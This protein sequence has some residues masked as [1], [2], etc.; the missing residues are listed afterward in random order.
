MGK[1]P[2]PADGHRSPAE[3]AHRDYTGAVY[4]SLLA[5]SVV[6]GAASLGRF[7]RLEMIILLLGTSTVFWAAHVHARLFG[8][9]AVFQSMSVADIR[10][11]CAEEWPIVT[12][13]VP[14]AV[15]VAVGPLLGLEAQ[16][17]AWLALG[18]A[19]AGQVGW[20]AAAA[21]GIGASARMVLVTSVI[22]LL[23][24]LVIVVLKA[25]FHH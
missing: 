6:A 11:A 13:A 9:R 25:A 23:L 21:V 4:G 16:G 5:A 14:P 2:D 10:R 22:N 17:T 3:G 19:V 8:A 7:P 1:V 12:A 20:S 18:V 15:A 24:G